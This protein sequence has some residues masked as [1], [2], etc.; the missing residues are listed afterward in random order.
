MLRKPKFEDEATLQHRSVAKHRRNSR[1]KATE[2]DPLALASHLVA[3]ARPR[4]IA[5]ALLE[6]LLERLGRGVR[7]HV[8]F[9]MPPKSR[10]ERATSPS[11]ERFTSP[12]RSAWAATC[13]RNSG[14]RAAFARSFS[15]RAGDI[16]GTEPNH[17]RSCDGTSA[18]C[19]TTLDRR[20]VEG[21]IFEWSIDA[22]GDVLS[23]RGEGSRPAVVAGASA[24][25]ELASSLRITAAQADVSAEAAASILVRERTDEDAAVALGF[26]RPHFVSAAQGNWR[27]RMIGARW[28]VN[29]AHDD[30]VALRGSSRSR[31]RCLVSLLAR[32][33]VIRSTSQES[34]GPLDA[35]LDILAHAERNL[36]ARDDLLRQNQRR[37]PRLGSA[38]AGS[39]RWWPIPT[40]PTAPCSRS[41][42]SEGNLVPWPG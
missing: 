6:R 33:I 9:G 10:R 15:V 34:T 31:L 5:N 37:T 21:V 23:L 22:P 7:A 26:P 36:R 8:H 39:R 27:S 16:T 3:Q 35:M 30:Y 32:E 14:D 13:W 20:R 40:G 25:P 42:P 28:E 12:R 29:D 2:H 24:L 41:L 1:E 11:S 18:W 19:T 17:A 38:R 4:G